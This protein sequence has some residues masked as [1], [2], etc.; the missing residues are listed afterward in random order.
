MRPQRGDTLTWLENGGGRVAIGA[1]GSRQQYRY[2]DVGHKLA[3]YAKAV[4]IDGH[5]PVQIAACATYA[6]PT[7]DQAEA[8][9]A[10]AFALEQGGMPRGDAVYQSLELVI[11]GFVD[12]G[13]EHRQ[14]LID[15]IVSL[16]QD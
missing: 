15:S 4:D 8:M 12:H 9:V 5:I 1:Y 14:L 2:A 6:L 16:A 3:Y 10:L 7:M 13:P 11:N